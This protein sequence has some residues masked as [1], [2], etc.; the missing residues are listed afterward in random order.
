MA[1]LDGVRAVAVLLVVGT[2][3]A[4]LS[5]AVGSTGLLGHLLGRGDL[6]VSIFFTLSGY[7]LHAGL[8]R[9]GGATSWRH[10]A[11]RRAAR[12]LPAY[13]LVLAVV[14]LAVRPAWDVT[15][16]HA[17]L[18]QIY[19]PDAD[20]PAFSQSWS[21]ATEA[22]FYA[23]L[24]FAAMGLARLRRRSPDLAVTV[25][26]WT[27]V[28]T[29]AL[30]WVISAGE[31]GREA[32]YE[33]WLPARAGSFALGML[34]AEVRANPGHPLSRWARALADAPGP[35]LAVGAAAYL[36]AT[37]PVAGLLTLGV[38]AGW[39]LGAKM[40]LSC[41]VAGAL[42][43]PVALR[44]GGPVGTALGRPVV[45]W[46]GRVSYGVFL[47]H[48]P[49]FVALYDLTGARVFAGGLGAMLALLA[50]GLPVSLLLGWLSHRFVE[51]PVMRRAAAL[52]RTDDEHRGEGRQGEQAGRRLDDRAAQG[53]G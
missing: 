36:L 6:G 26:A 30:S 50:V 53:G 48:V 4:F 14:V 16:L 31:I 51:L 18:L 40:L 21:V 32:L 11:L 5:G 33:R 43:L 23:V 7:L 20:L 25:M 52:G 19:A 3:A 35:L 22:A 38:V 29:L 24:P 37:T 8:L 15:A 46:A 12:I 10:Y 49:V 13:W 17:A 1:A 41:L 2:H 9:D 47:W 27:L 39:Q 28:G 42:L 34:V 45:A 44:P